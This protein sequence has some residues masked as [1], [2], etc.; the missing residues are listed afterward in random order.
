MDSN[1]FGTYNLI[2][3]NSSKLSNIFFNN[4]NEKD[5]MRIKLLYKFIIENKNLIEITLTKNPMKSKFLMQKIEDNR[6][7]FNFNNYV[8]KDENQN[9]EINCL[10]S[11]LWKIKIEIED[12]NKNNINE[13]RPKFNLKFDCANKNNNNSCE[14]DFSKNFI[15]F[16]NSK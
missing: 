9:I 4:N 3:K 10:Y 12:E 11:F 7:S 16:N 15:I 13:A 2:N 14:F 6:S 8:K 1:N 5:I